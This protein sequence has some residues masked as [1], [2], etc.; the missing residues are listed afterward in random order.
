MLDRLRRAGIED[1]ILLD[2]GCGTGNM[3]E[4]L[5]DAGYD[6]IGVDLS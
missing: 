1:G 6:M 3:T 5:A 4:L 2:L